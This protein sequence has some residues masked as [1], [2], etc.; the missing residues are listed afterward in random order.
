MIWLIRAL[1]NVPHENVDVTAD[2]ELSDD[3]LGQ[4]GGGLA[5]IGVGVTIL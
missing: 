5:K 2:D 4:V 3:Q 1:T